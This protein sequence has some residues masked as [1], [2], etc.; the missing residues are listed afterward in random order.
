MDTIVR[1]IHAVNRPEALLAV[2][3]AQV[4]I[5]MR[6]HDGARE[7]ERPTALHHWQIPAAQWETI[8]AAACARAQEWGSAAQLRADL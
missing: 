2:T 6:H 4:H 7:A 5:A 1:G 3:L 8:V